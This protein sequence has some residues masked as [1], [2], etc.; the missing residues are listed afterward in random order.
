MEAEGLW[1]IDTPD[2]VKN[3]HGWLNVQLENFRQFDGREILRRWD[4]VRSF[5][6]WLQFWGQMSNYSGP[7]ESAIPPRL[8][9]EEVGCCLDKI[10]FHHR[11]L[12]DLPEVARRITVSGGHVGYYSRPAQDAR[13]DVELR[14]SNGQ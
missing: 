1:P 11:Y 10:A 8:T 7:A 4:V 12:P 3:A 5:M 14:G 13:L 2:Y 9:D 6:P